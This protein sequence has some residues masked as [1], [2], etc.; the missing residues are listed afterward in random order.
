M[1]TRVV[2]LRRY[3]VKSMGGEPLHVAELDRRG[4]VG[5]RGY[6]VVDEDG[7]FA[8]GKTTRRFR[9]RDAVFEFA[10]HTVE[11]EVWVLRRDRAWRIGDPALDATLSEALEATVTVAAEDS[12]PHHDAGPVSIVGTA[13]LEWCR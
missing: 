7:R 12:V 13:S 2:A 9:R 1:H 11:D 6:A 8:S 5:D 10:A 3:P 4:L